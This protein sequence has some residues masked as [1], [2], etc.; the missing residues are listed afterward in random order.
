MISSCPA[1]S[2]SPTFT[3]TSA[4]RSSFSSNAKSANFVALTASATLIAI[5]PYPLHLRVNILKVVAA[6]PRRQPLRRP[7][8]T[9]G[10]PAPR[11]RVMRQHQPVRIALRYQDMRSGSI[12]HAVRLY[13]N[14]VQ[15]GSLLHHPGQA[16]RRSRGRVQ[17][18]HMVRLFNR[19][20][21]PCT[22]QQRAHL[23]CQ[24]QHHLHADREVRP[25]QQR[26]LLALGQP[27]HIRQLVVPARRADHHLRARRQARAHVLHRRIGSREVNH[28]IEPGHKWRRQC[29][30]IRILLGVEHMHAVAVLRR[31]LRYQL[32]CLPMS[33]HQY[34]H[35]LPSYALLSSC[36]RASTSKT[37]ASGSAKKTPCRLRT[38]S[39]TSSSSIIK[40]MLISLA[41]SEI[42][43]RFTWLTAVTTPAAIPLCPP[44]SSPTSPTSA[45]WPST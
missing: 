26:R 40:L 11:V 10:K 31:N 29:R 2:P 25:V 41:P 6:R 27:A 9:L 35:R 15:P 43:R 30:R 12:A 21:V 37:V 14:I 16:D 1:R 3:A 5:S 19:E 20:L 24:L 7:Y 34:S 18:R 17:L 32:A 28:H 42:I 13:R 36:T 33:Q 45:F 39:S 44:M 22:L 23:R 38:S 4:S 8:R